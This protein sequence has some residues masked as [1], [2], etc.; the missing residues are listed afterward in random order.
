LYA[1]AVHR[2][3]FVERRER[4]STKMESVRAGSSPAF[5]P[6]VGMMRFVSRI[7]TRTRVSTRWRRILDDGLIAKPA[8]GE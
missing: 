7:A 6:S 5:A 1:S 2:Q 8:I 4:E 3:V